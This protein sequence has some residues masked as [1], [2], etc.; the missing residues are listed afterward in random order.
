MQ[1]PSV[2]PPTPITPGIVAGGETQDSEPRLPTEAT[3]TTPRRL[4]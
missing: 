3:R 1:P 2:L 4:A